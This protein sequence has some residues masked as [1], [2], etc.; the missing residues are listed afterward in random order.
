MVLFEAGKLTHRKFLS[1]WKLSELKGIEVTPE[2]VTLGA[3]TTYTQV[4]AHA[5]L[6][7]E[8][9]LLCQAARET[10]GIATQNRG[11]LSRK[12]VNGAP[13][14]DSPPPLLVYD[15]QNELGSPRGSRW[16]AHQSFPTG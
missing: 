2:H 10:G 13:A 12:I 14:A 6:Q 7:R 3:L 1:I 15:P 4:Q 16:G 9:P 5:V 8:F 11:T